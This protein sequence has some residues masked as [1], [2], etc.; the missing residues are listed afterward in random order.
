MRRLARNQ[1]CEGVELVNR[2]GDPAVQKIRD[3]A[4]VDCAGLL[5]GRLRAR[6]AGQSE[7]REQMNDHASRH[8]ILPHRE[9]QYVNLMA[10]M[11]L[12]GRSMSGP[13]ALVSQPSSVRPATEMNGKDES[14]LPAH[15]DAIAIVNG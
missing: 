8:L 9:S 14:S 7:D 6:R 10:S 4:A 15:G 5:G 3:G 12:R 13:A 2:A 11:R 1:T